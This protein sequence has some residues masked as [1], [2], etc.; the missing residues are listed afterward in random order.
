MFTHPLSLQIVVAMILHM[1]INLGINPAEQG[2]L[3][4]GFFQ[5][6]SENLFEQFQAFQ[7]WAPPF[8]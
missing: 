8:V 1:G 3:W 5:I 6:K 2:F 7:T 4:S